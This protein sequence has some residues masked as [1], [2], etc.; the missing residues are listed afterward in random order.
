M[1]DTILFSALPQKSEVDL[2]WVL[3]MVEE[4][5]LLYQESTPLFLGPVRPGS[6]RVKYGATDLGDVGTF[7]ILWLP[8]GHACRKYET[9]LPGQEQRVKVGSILS[10]GGAG[11]Y[12][13]LYSVCRN[14]FENIFVP[15][16]ERAMI[17]SAE[18]KCAVVSWE[19]GRFIDIFFDPRTTVE[20]ILS[21]II[22]L[23]SGTPELRG[24][25]NA[26][27]F[28]IFIEELRYVQRTKLKKGSR[29]Y[30]LAEGIFTLSADVENYDIL[31]Y[32]AVEVRRFIKSLLGDAQYDSVLSTFQSYTDCVGIPLLYFF[33]YNVLRVCIFIMRQYFEGVYF[34]G[35]DFR[36]KQLLHVEVSP[37]TRTRDSVRSLSKQAKI[38]MWYAELSKNNGTGVFCN[39]CGKK[40]DFNNFEVDH[41]FPWSKGGKTE[42]GN[43]QVLCKSCNRTKSATVNSPGNHATV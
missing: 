16:R 13:E 27:D 37:D 12:E 5:R 32:A 33:D 10:E 35:G 7:G 6:V 26:N 42:P 8:R 17:L 21:A 43:L 39:M 15:S 34:M 2:D 23:E 40:L 1:R 9:T 20:R 31:F 19:S 18:R 41:V 38:A 36:P 25:I 4:T 14:G 28:K 22:L 24:A 11:E 3:S 30:D 29:R